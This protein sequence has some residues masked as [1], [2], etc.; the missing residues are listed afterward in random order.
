MSPHNR[1]V[2]SLTAT[3]FSQPVISQGLSYFLLWKPKMKNMIY[4]QFLH[5]PTNQTEHKQPLSL[6]YNEIIFK[7]TQ[8]TIKAN[9]PIPR[10]QNP[11]INWKINTLL[12]LVTPFFE[13]PGPGGWL[14]LATEVETRRSR[15]SSGD[16]AARLVKLVKRWSAF[17]AQYLKFYTFSKNIIISQL[18]SCS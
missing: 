2:M 8:L 3:L 16:A 13:P 15:P 17:K 12:R 5:F 7:D 6:E 1:Y 9:K 14:L 10:L 4:L 18:L 11:Q